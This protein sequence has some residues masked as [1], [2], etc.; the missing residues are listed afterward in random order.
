MKREEFPYKANFCSHFDVP[1]THT[2]PH[3]NIHK[4]PHTHT[5]SH[6]HTRTPTHP[7]T[8]TPS[9]PHTPTPP[10]TH[11][12]TTIPTH[13]IFH[14][15]VD[16]ASGSVCLDVINQSWKP[17]FDLTNIFEVRVLFAYVL[18]LCLYVCMF[19]NVL[20]VGSLFFLFRVGSLSLTSPTFARYAYY[21]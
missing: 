14:P 18:Y 7:H 9:H 11:T 5:S 3:T 15:N 17:F 19:T 12:H 10:H 6:P 21:Y 1:P 16:E 4:H 8:L 13:R 20:R 2:H